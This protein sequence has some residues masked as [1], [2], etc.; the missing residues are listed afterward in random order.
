[1]KHRP[2]SLLI[3]AAEQP[4]FKRFKFPFDN[5][6]KDTIKAVPGSAWEPE[7]K[8]WLVPDELAESMA[9][10]AERW[11]YDITW[12]KA[13][14]VAGGIHV[15]EE[16]LNPLLHDYQKRAVQKCLHL[17]RYI[18]AFETGLGKTP[19]GIEVV[20]HLGSKPRCLIVCPALIRRVW[21]VEISKWSKF[22]E[23]SVGLIR[24][25]WGNNSL[26]KKQQQERANAHEKPIQIVSYDLL[27]EVRFEGWSAIIFDEA[28]LLKNARAKRTTIARDLVEANPSAMVLGLTATLLPE[29]PADC[30]GVIDTI[31]PGRAGS[32]FKFKHRYMNASQNE[33]GWEFEGLDEEHSRELQ[34]RLSRL[35]TRV[36]KHEVAHLL[37]TFIVEELR[38]GAEGRQPRLS[39]ANQFTKD[40]DEHSCVL[41]YH[42]SL[43]K[44]I[45]EA[46][47]ALCITGEMPPE[48]RH[49]VI[50]EAKDNRQTLVA[51]MRSV[52]QGI[53]LTFF[54]QCLFAELPC[55]LEVM[56]Q[57]LGRFSR[58]SGRTPTKVSLLVLENTLDELVA[59]RLLAKVADINAVTKTSTSEDALREA[60]AVDEDAWKA[61]LAAYAEKHDIV[62]GADE[63]YLE[64]W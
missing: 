17:G 8:S 38:L 31:W 42:R 7:T 24:F 59:G 58:L 16:I 34:L 25:G 60:F 39:A 10:N 9:W 21:Q 14:T 44:Q 54:D 26:T 13:A 36:T 35:S 30:H 63:D 48:K 41:V 4:W 6:L 62:F 45:A 49:E 55:Q 1:M 40:S 46:L 28:H 2:K 27:S 5:K 56:V 15:K 64:D 29:R 32:A 57:T 61:E 3:S 47:S 52:G 50:R 23:D 18:L 20:Q 19:T 12:G 37:P 33:Y 22:S 11:G 53:D 43:A 51:T